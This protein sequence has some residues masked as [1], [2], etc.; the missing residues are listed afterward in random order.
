MPFDSLPEPGSVKGWGKVIFASSWNCCPW[1]S[2][3]HWLCACWTSTWA[4]CDQAMFFLQPVPCFLFCFKPTLRYTTATDGAL[5]QY[6]WRTI[7]QYLDSN[8]K[9]VRCFCIGIESCLQRFPHPES[10]LSCHVA[11]GQTFSSYS[12]TSWLYTQP[13]WPQERVRSSWQADDL[14][15]LCCLLSEVLSEVSFPE[16]DSAFCR[17]N[18]CPLLFPGFLHI[19]LYCWPCFLFVLCFLRPSRTDL[20]KIHRLVSFVSPLSI[21]IYHDL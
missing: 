9:K 18:P 19:L 5:A 13:S 20:S 8:F 21:C 12:Q 7:S 10:K 2:E 16:Q 15:W 17:C 4:K 3:W 6:S 11:T 1:E 14:L